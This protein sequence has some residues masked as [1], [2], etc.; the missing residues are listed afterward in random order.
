MTRVLC[1][2]RVGEAVPRAENF[3][4]TKTAEHKILNEDGESRNS[5][6]CRSAR[7]CHSVDS[8]LSVWMKTS[9]ETEKSLRKFLEPSEKPKVIDTDSSLEFAYCADLSWNHRIS[10]PHRSETTGIA[11]RNFSSI[12]TIRMNC[13]GLILWNAV[14]ICD[15]L[16]DGETSYGRRF[17][18][19][20][21]RLNIIRFL[22]E[23]NQDFSNSAR[24]V[25]Q[26]SF[27]C[28]HWSREEFGKEMFWLRIWKNWKKLDS[29]EIS[30]YW[31]HKMAEEFKLPVADG[32]AKLFRR[33]FELPEPTLKAG[34]N[35][36]ERRSQWRNSR[37]IGKS[38]TWH[39]QKM[40]QKPV[41]TFGRLS[42]WTSSSTLRVEGR[43]M[44]FSTEIHGC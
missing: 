35:R 37:R 29:S 9:Q 20:E 36:K 19:P 30:K 4:D 27:M 43:N 10:A 13:G 14:A 38:L 31:S 21:Q 41:P 44:P 33:D 23:I 8:I 12:A 7:S 42:Q 1:R 32:A 6:R 18:E 5:H 25:C 3:G 40:T 11:E 24:R 17:G 2:R 16:A 22:H 34:T 15:L 39:N 28:M 26:K